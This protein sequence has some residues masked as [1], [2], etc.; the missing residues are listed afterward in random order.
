[1]TPLEH[2][3]RAIAEL[4][5]RGGGFIPLRPIDP[6]M[7]I[8]P[9]DTSLDFKCTLSDEAVEALNSFGADQAKIHDERLQAE[10][11]RWCWRAIAQGVGNRIWR[12]DPILN[13]DTFVTTY[14]FA[15]L[16]PGEAAPGSGIVFGPFSKP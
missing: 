7:K 13:E 3:A 4:D 12:S 8:K 10:T 16:K 15:I 14:Q 6:P 1:M 2:A 5:M 9:L 11:D